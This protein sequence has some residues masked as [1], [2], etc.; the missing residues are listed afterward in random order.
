[1][2]LAIIKSALTA[3]ICAIF[4]AGTA[5]ALE[6]LP[7]G[8]K[9]LA[10][11]SPYN[12]TNKTSIKLA[13]DKRGNVLVIKVIN[14]CLNDWKAFERV[15]RLYSNEINAFELIQK[16][17]PVPGII[18]YIGKH[19]G[20]SYYILL[21]YAQ[22]GDL[23]GVIEKEE[24]LSEDRARDLFRQ[25]AETLAFLH[26]KLK[27][28]HCDIKPENFLMTDDATVKMSDFG[29]SEIFESDDEPKSFKYK[30][31]RKNMAPEV[32]GIKSEE[33]F[34]HPFRADVYSLAIV[35]FNMLSGAPPYKEIGDRYYILL[36]ESFAEAIA[37]QDSYEHYFDYYTS[38]C[39]WI[40]VNPVALGLI[41]QMMSLDPVQRPTMKQVLSHPW[42]NPRRLKITS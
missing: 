20:Q 33:D 21:E 11:L 19:E 26:E 10:E 28:A 15:K 18:G 31:T 35:L 36:R 9:P 37:R 4:M 14:K 24:G 29:E 8:F 1:M 3:F 27:M 13:E 32:F 40:R 17:G 38:L 42:L 22:F 2:Q 5:L 7:S 6:T 30:G 16:H 41:A 39:P 12:A 23:Y 34:Y 25:M